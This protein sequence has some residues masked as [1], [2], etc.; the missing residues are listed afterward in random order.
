[1]SDNDI[2]FLREEAAK[3]EAAGNFRL[4]NQLFTSVEY[5]HADIVR[6]AFNPSGVRMAFGEFIPN[7][8]ENEIAVV[9][10]LIG[11]SIPHQIARDLIG[12][13]QKHVKAIDDAAKTEKDDPKEGNAKQT[14]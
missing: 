10:P 2:R 6:L 1:M 7:P 11:I 9:R 13:L 3:E 8:S 5:K 12:Y 4:I 14:S